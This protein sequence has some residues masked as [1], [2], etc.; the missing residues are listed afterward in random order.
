[1]LG[2]TPLSPLSVALGKSAANAIR[3]LTLWLAPLPILTV[4]LLLGGVSG[5]EVATVVLFQITLLAVGLAAGLAAS[6]YAIEFRRAL[7]LA[8][9]FEALLIPTV[10]FLT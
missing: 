7:A 10:L 5:I 9:L 6:T 2:L 1:M 8:Y 3:A 4:P